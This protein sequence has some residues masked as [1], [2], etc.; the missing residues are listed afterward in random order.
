MQ[1]QR[2]GVLVTVAVNYDTPTALCIVAFD[3]RV[4][5]GSNTGRVEMG[6]VTIPDG[7]VAGA[8]YYLDIPNA[9]DKDNGEVIAGGEVV[10][11][12][13]Q[14]GTGGGAIAGDFQ[15]FVCWVPRGLAPLQNINGNSVVTLI[16]D[17]T[18]VQV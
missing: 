5:Y 2:V 12:I 10:A 17:T 4:I 15:P 1:V 16:Q 14:A 18:T 7:A 9:A 6:R 11:E 3:R 8:V 13:V